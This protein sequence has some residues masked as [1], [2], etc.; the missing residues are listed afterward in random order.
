M[1]EI[2]LPSAEPAVPSNAHWMPLTSI[3]AAAS[4]AIFGSSY[5]AGTVPLAILSALLSPLTYVVTIELWGSRWVAIVAGILAIFA[6]PLLIMYPTTDNFAVFGA[7]GA[8]SLYC[9]MRAVRSPVAGRW[10]VAAAAFAGL[11]TLARID[12]AL[13]T[14]AVATAWLVRRGWGPWKAGPGAVSVW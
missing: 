5:V 13:L 11:A 7:T 2:S 1:G 3:V 9:S 4:M 10:L 12:G 8:A 6:G 14:F